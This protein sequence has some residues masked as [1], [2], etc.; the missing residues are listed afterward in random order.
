MILVQCPTDSVYE[1]ILQ[2]DGR[3]WTVK[4]DCWLFVYW[5]G[6]DSEFGSDVLDK[7]FPRLDMAQ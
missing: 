7:F 3:R 2:F 1:S 4:P 6:N 5:D